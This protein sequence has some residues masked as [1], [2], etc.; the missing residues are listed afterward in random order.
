MKCSVHVCVRVYAHRPHRKSE[1][2]GEKVAV[3]GEIGGNEMSEFR[4]VFCSRP[5]RASDARGTRTKERVTAS[6]R[7]AEEET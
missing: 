7:R 4:D 3:V 1:Q 2:D 6:V 5:A